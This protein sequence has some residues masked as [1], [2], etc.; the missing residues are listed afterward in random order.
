MKQL[1]NEGGIKEISAEKTGI[2]P[3]PVSS[4]DH[5]HHVGFD[6]RSIRGSSHYNDC[7]CAC[8][9]FVRHPFQRFP[10][11]TQTHFKRPF[12]LI[13]S[14][15]LLPFIAF[16]LSMGLPSFRNIP[17]PKTSA[18]Q[19]SNKEI[20]AIQHAVGTSILLAGLGTSFLVQND[21]M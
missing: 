6:S 18:F 17:A 7:P 1:L 9:T 21:V 19:D 14:R 5:R 16:A 20:Y 13:I 3:S 2:F 10:F 4:V 12:W 15:I 11:I 8:A